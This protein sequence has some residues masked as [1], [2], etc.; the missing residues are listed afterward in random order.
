[1]QSLG[2]GNQSASGISAAFSNRPEPSLKKPGIGSQ[3][4]MGDIYS[5]SEIGPYDDPIGRYDG[6]DEEIEDEYSDVGD[7]DGSR[8]AFDSLSRHNGT[9]S[10]NNQLGAGGI[11][12]YGGAAGPIGNHV[13]EAMLLRDEILLE[14]FIREVLSENS[15]ARGMNPG[16]KGYSS[17]GADTYQSAIQLGNTSKK[18]RPF[19]M[20]NIIHQNMNAN[21]GIQ[22]RWDR[23]PRTGDPK[24]W[25]GGRAIEV[26]KHEKVVDDEMKRKNGIGLSTWEMFVDSQEEKDEKYIKNI[27]KREDNLKNK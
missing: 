18:M 7:I 17:F 16:I 27:R 10:Q 25:V 15:V 9:F 21:G 12:S 13:S 11:G 24:S 22:R 23:R 8:V 1:M 5:S 26:Q 19:K 20:N 3:L 2:T 4:N 6:E 14:N